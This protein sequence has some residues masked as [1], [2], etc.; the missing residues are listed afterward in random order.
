M[1]GGFVLYPETAYVVVALTRGEITDTK[2]F[3]WDPAAEAFQETSLLA[4]GA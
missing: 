1:P 4:G 3:R 2:A